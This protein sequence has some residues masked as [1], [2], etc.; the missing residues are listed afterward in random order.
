MNM[1]SGAANTKPQRTSAIN[2]VQ[3]IDQNLVVVAGLNNE[4]NSI[5][6]AQRAVERLR[7]I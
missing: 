5:P 2:Y 3:S 6:F 4:V 1:R 7:S